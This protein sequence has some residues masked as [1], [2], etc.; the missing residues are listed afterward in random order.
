VQPKV[1]A[2]IISFAWSCLDETDRIQI[3]EHLRG[4]NEKPQRVRRKTDLSRESV[5][6]ALSSTDTVGKAAEVLGCSRRTLQ[7]RMR[8][9]EIPEGQPGRPARI[10]IK[11]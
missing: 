5:E 10:E 7:N 9:Y 4:V 11:K 3:L 1:V 6:A 8:L 2:E